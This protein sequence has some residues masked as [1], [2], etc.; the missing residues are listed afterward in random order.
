MNKLVQR[1]RPM[2]FIAMAAIVLLSIW[3]LHLLRSFDLP[4]EV[5]SGV[6]MAIISSSITSLGMMGLKLVEEPAPPTVPLSVHSE[7]LKIGLKK[8]IK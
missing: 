7:A 4:P 6:I 1:I 3:I 2:L 8:E 5:T